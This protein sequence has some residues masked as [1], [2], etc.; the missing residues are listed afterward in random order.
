MLRALILGHALDPVA[1]AVASALL[2]TGTFCVERATIEQLAAARWEHRLNACGAVNTTLRFRDGIDSRSHVVFNRLS[3]VSTPYFNA[4]SS[5]DRDYACAELTAL[6][7]S[8]LESLGGRVVNRPSFGSLAGPVD[9]PWQWIAHAAA[10]GFVPHA[11]GA[12]TSTRRFVPPS[13]ALERMEMLPALVFPGLDRPLGYAGP[14]AALIDLLV[15]GDTI[16]GGAEAASAHLAC[17]RLAQMTQTD[18]LGVRLARIAPEI[19][20][21]IVDDATWRFVSAT[22]AP[23]IEGE[24]AMAALISLL[25]Q[26]ATGAYACVTS[27]TGHP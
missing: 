21:E 3:A 7:L 24:E 11:T 8:W 23:A 9:K 5:V 19:A 12:T 14:A 16:V 6:L 18:V 1:N 15:V 2:R 10:A 27:A 26:R 20:P 25:E 22:S 17:L 4:W 13:D